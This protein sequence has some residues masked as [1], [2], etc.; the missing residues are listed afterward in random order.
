MSFGPFG[1]LF[2]GGLLAR[3]SGSREQLLLHHGIRN[4]AGRNGLHHL[5]HCPEGVAA[6]QIGAL[7]ESFPSQIGHGPGSPDFGYMLAVRT[8]NEHAVF[9]RFDPV[10]EFLIGNRLQASSSLDEQGCNRFL[11][12]VSSRF[13]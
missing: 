2:I 13:E 6:R 4:G 11:N 3:P 8:F 5:S 12:H 1:G 7:A 10:Q 9:S